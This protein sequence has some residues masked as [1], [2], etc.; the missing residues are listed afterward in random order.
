MQFELTIDTCAPG[1]EKTALEALSAGLRVPSTPGEPVLEG[2]WT[3]EFGEVG[4]VLSLWSVP[5]D[6]ALRVP[7]ELPATVIRETRRLK[8]EF[9][10]DREF[11]GG[12]VYDFRVYTLR[13]GM[14]DRF[15]EHMRQA[16]PLRKQFSRNVGIWTPLTG[17]RDQIFHIW[18]Y[19]DLA[20][21]KQVR[22]ATSGEQEWNAYLREIFPL[23]LRMQNALLV[24]AGFSPMQ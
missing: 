5:D 1:T 11:A 4:Q 22:M 7:N 9:P 19:R 2:S 13:V 16:M 17:N 18:A 20:E 15:L 10:F 12:H 14:R 21:R 24:P 23:T 3:T 8:P 6:S